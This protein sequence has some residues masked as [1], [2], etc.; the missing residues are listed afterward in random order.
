M[1]YPAQTTTA[2][3]HQ[4]AASPAAAGGLRGAAR[5]RAV[6]ALRRLATQQVDGAPFRLVPPDGNAIDF[7]RG[8]PRFTLRVVRPEGLDAIASFD[9]LTIA[10]AYMDGQLDFE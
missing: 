5:E 8:E 4:R 10:H 3:T 1:S 6:A 9:A 7:G 2:Q